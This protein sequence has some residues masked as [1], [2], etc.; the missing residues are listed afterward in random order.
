MLLNDLSKYKGLLSD[1][2]IYGINRGAGL[3]QALALM[4]ASGPS[5]SPT[6]FASILQQGLQQGRQAQEQGVQ[7][8]LQNQQLRRKAEEEKML[9]GIESQLQG[10]GNAGMTPQMALGEQGGQ[11]GPTMQRAGMIG[12]GAPTDNKAKAALYMDAAMKLSVRNP[13]RAEQYFKLA[14][15]LDP[16]QDSLFDKIDPSKFDPA[17]VRLFTQTG[18]YGDLVAKNDDPEAIRTLRIL[19]QN[20]DLA[21]LS[22]QQKRAGAANIQNG[23][24]NTDTKLFEGEQGLRKEFKDTPTAKA[25]NEVKFAYDQVSTALK[26]PSAANDLTAATKFMKILDPGSVVRESELGLAMSATGLFDRVGNYYSQ[27]ITGQRLTPSQR[28]DFYRSATQL[29]NAALQPYS[30]TRAQ[31]EDVTKRYGFDP[32]RVLGGEAPKPIPER[33]LDAKTD[34]A[35]AAKAELERRRKANNGS[36]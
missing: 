12:Q 11:A 5:T 6:S 21:A 15:R 32:A 18:N 35:S 1:D 33:K 27:L 3:E 4:A 36:K 19:Q 26:N 14:E 9:Q 30:A 10:G 24:F 31:Y 29:Y 2:D 8:A 23:T 13:E 17:S 16:K 7:G 34:P 25:Y 22:A 20:P 28:E